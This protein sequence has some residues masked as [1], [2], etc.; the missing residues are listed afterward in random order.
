MQT[1][2]CHGLLRPASGPAAE[3]VCVARP[4]PPSDFAGSA[5]DKFSK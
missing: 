4:T 5:G 2:F 3:S 1:D